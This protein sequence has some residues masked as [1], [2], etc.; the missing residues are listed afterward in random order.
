MISQQSHAAIEQAGSQALAILYGY[1]PGTDLNF[2]KAVSSSSY[3]PLLILPDSMVSVQVWL[4]YNMEATDWGWVF[5][6]CLL[7]PNRMGQLTAPVPLLKLIRCNCKCGQC[8]EITC[9]SSGSSIN[10]D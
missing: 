4:G 2:E 10:I 9:K 3:L 8:K 5:D 7:K 1:I 6:G